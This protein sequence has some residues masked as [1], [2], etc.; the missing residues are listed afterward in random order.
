M[1]RKFTIVLLVIAAGIFAGCESTST[2]KSKPNSSV[3]DLLKKLQNLD[4]LK[5]VSCN[6]T[7]TQTSKQSRL[8]AP[9]DTQL[10]LTGSVTLSDESFSMIKSKYNW[11]PVSQTEIPQSLLSILPEGDFLVSKKFNESFETNSG[12][13]FGFVV[14]LANDS[15]KILYISAKYFN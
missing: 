12:Y 5:I 7:I 11:Q 10:E 1:M 6:Y 15:S 4:S 2:T 8:P 14:R 13:K 9:S 3:S